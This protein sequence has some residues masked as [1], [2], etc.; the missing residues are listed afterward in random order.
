[1]SAYKFKGWENIDG[2]SVTREETDSAF[3]VVMHSAREIEAAYQVR[4]KAVKRAKV[5]RIMMY[6]AAALILIASPLAIHHMM[7]NE[8]TGLMATSSLTTDHGEIQEITLPDGSIVTLNSGS[9]L[10]WP[11]EFSKNRVVTLTGEALFDVTADRKHKFIVRTGDLQ[12]T[13][14][15]TVFDV[16]DY[17]EDG[18]ATVTLCKG[19]VA[20]ERAEEGVQS[21]TLTPD[22]TYI[23]DKESGAVTVKVID[24]AEATLWTGGHIYIKSQ[25]LEQAARMVERRFGVNIHFLT[26]KHQETVLTAK[27]ANGETLHEIMAAIRQLVP[28]MEYSIEEKDIFIR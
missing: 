6:A 19:S 4:Q 20:V 16:C 23:Y 11:D 24:A 5:M 2:S 7:N 8:E 1:M 22:H 28:E 26:D 25:T 27:F 17:P 21:A 10:T 9:T 3:K 12:V 15:G 13:V 14:H 18:C